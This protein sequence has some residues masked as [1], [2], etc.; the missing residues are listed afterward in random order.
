[1]N[2]KLTAHQLTAHRLVALTAPAVMTESMT[3]SVDSNHLPILSFNS[4]IGKFLW[5]LWVLCEIY[6]CSRADYFFTQ[7]TQSFYS[8]SCLTLALKASQTSLRQKDTATR[9]IGWSSV[10]VSFCCTINKT[11]LSYQQNF[12]DSTTK[13]YK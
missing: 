11:L 3:Y 10:A 2:E 6:Y 13:V 5:V 7:R 1:M 4:H 12:V 8:P 9:N